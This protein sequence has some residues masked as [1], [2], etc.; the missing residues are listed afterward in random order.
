MSGVQ[1]SSRSIALGKF[2]SGTDQTFLRQR[3]V[4]CPLCGDSPPGT[5]VSELRHSDF[6]DPWRG[7]GPER[8][9]RSWWPYGHGNRR[10]G[11]GAP[12]WAGK[13]FSWEN[14]LWHTVR[15]SAGRSGGRLP[16]QGVCAPVARGL[17]PCASRLVWVDILDVQA[18]QKASPLSGERRPIWLSIVFPVCSGKQVNPFTRE[19][20][21]RQGWN[22]PAGSLSV[23]CPAKGRLIFFWAAARTADLSS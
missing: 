20:G 16:A 6:C 1:P 17:S 23:N 8:R 22:S 21:L 13:F 5:R 2:G 9:G 10:Y 3:E 14:L 18:L 15:T 11:R 4:G 19:Y 7:G 12:C